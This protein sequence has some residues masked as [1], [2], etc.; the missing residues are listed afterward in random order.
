MIEDDETVY[1]LVEAARQGDQAAWNVLVH[2]YAP[3]VWAVTRTYRLGEKDAE[4]VSQFV[5]L[6]LVEQLARIREPLA[7]PRWI[8]TTAR[9]ES[10]RLV[11]RLNR[12]VLVDP[13]A[14][15]RQD[16]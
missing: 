6:R 8:I 13:L 7:L 4:D 12:T 14:D 3:L 11:A 1:A 10:Q 9:R 5:W 2:R 15:T 16:F